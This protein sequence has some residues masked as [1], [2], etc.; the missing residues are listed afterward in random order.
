MKNDGASKDYKFGNKNNWRR[1]NWNRIEER[2][3]VPKKEAKILY[4]AGENN[5]DMQEASRRGFNCR[6]MIAIERD[7]ALAEELRSCSVTTFNGTLREAIRN[8]GGEKIDVVIGDYCCGLNS[9]VS[10]QVS[11][12][13]W[14]PCFSDCVFSINL[15]RGRETLSEEMRSHIS[16][17]SK[18]RGQSFAGL[19]CGVSHFLCTKREDFISIDAP[20]ITDEI[21]RS[22]GNFAYNEYRSGNLFFDSTVYLNPSLNWLRMVNAAL[23]EAADLAQLLEQDS[24]GKDKNHYFKFA[25]DFLTPKYIKLYEKS[26]NALSWK[27]KD[28]R[29]IAAKAVRSLRLKLAA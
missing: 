17:N 7:K 20:K 10:A 16:N 12:N 24:P 23:S 1:W 15:L 21:I 4:L 2:I 29:I 19:V 8:W 22:R 13:F 25:F 9:D 14:L 26:D 3:S 5:L 18:H 28:R 6:N 11:D 27:C